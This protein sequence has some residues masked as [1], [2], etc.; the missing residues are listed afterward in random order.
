MCSFVFMN[1][2]HVVCVLAASCTSD[3]AAVLAA[4]KRSEEIYSAAHFE[5]DF[6]E[7]WRDENHV[8][9]LSF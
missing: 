2:G 4:F 6:V 7:I 5:F 3:E 8:V 1:C 9:T